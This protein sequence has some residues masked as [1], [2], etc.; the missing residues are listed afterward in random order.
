MGPP[1]A[2]FLD[3]GNLTLVQLPSSF[4]LYF[5]LAVNVTALAT[6]V[7]TPKKHPTLV[8]I[9]KLSQATFCG[10]FPTLGNLMFP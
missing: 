3:M 4:L 8:W 6:E 9:D 7:P 10:F 5:P 1:T 2:E